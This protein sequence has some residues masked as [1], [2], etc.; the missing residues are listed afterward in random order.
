MKKKNN[1]NNKNRII[2]LIV[3]LFLAIVY[4]IYHYAV[5]D[6]TFDKYKKDKSKNIIYSVYKEKD[7]NVP[8]INLKGVAIDEINNIIIDKANEFLRGKNNITY[9]FDIN[10]KILSLVIQYTDYYDEGG[11]PIVTCDVYNIN[12]YES[13]VLDNS[14]VLALYNITEEDVEP[15]VQSRFGEFYNELTEQKYYHGECDYDCFLSLRGI[16]NG[17]YM[18][19]INYY[20]KGGN[21]YALKTFKIYSPL[22]EENYFS[23]SD[24]LIQITK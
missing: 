17:N 19:N 15:I 3:V 13:K 11:Y 18:A 10:G 6:N 24:F 21:L 2:L 22:K 9:N 20:I 12:F 23:P 5:R 16:K 4:I 14:E 7:V 8:N 1:G